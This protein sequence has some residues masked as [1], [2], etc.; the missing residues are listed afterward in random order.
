MSMSKRYSHANFSSAP[1]WV[2]ARKHAHTAGGR[3]TRQLLYLHRY[4]IGCC[5]AD[6]PQQRY[7]WA[8]PLVA[9]ALAAARRRI[10]SLWS[11][12]TTMSHPPSRVCVHV[13]RVAPRGLCVCVLAT[14]I[15]GYTPGFDSLRRSFIRAFLR[16]PPPFV[17]F[18]R[19]YFVRPPGRTACPKSDTHKHTHER[20][21]E[22]TTGP[23]RSTVGGRF[24][25]GFG[26]ARLDQLS[27][28]TVR[29]KR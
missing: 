15:G 14:P 1:F 17:P 16:F 2:R 6:V 18:L 12:M 9:T 4:P 8:A 13:R 19:L 24:F 7:H 25:A 22:R 28:N 29:L 10:G 26:A 21:D 5:T 23:P 20:S 11:D 27:I 3:N